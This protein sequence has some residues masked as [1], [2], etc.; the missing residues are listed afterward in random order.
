M[1]SPYI[2]RERDRLQIGLHAEV[3]RVTPRTQQEAGIAHRAWEAR[4]KPLRPWLYDI[5]A[6]A[7][8][9]IFIISAWWALHQTFG[10]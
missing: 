8:I 2:A 3:R 10:G 7:G 9:V 1:V 4:M 5:A 6:G